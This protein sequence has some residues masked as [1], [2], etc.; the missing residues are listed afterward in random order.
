MAAAQD[1][2]DELMTDLQGAIG[3]DDDWT[4]WLSGQDAQGAGAS[5]AAAQLAAANDSTV[6]SIAPTVVNGYPGYQV[7]IETRYTVGK[8]IIPGTETRR[9]RAEAI[10]VIEPRCT[11][12]TDADPKRLVHLDC[13]GQSVDIDPAH[14]RS[15]DLPDASVL[16]SVHLAK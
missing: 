2:R 12:P 6:L 8:S 14:F 13:D 1:T 5:A 9:A 11:F 10:A 16:F 7:A 4:K 15:D 3:Q